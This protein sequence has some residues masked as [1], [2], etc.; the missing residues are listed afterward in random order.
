MDYLTLLGA[1]FIAWLVLVMLF[2]PHIPYRLEEP[3]DLSS[4]H[5]IRMI[6]STC[7]GAFRRGNR[8]EI[9][10]DGPAFYPAMLDGIRRA[11][12]TVNMEV[13]MFK[14]GEVAITVM[15]LHGC[16]RPGAASSR[17]SASRGTGSRA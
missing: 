12:E 3:L 10:T 17:I 4:E 15:W 16:G 2:A 7:Q 6:E 13:Y 9:L 1:A 14:R 8:V 5:F 11:R